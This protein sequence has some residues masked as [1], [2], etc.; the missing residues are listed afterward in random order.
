MN[1][2][3]HALAALVLG[4]SACASAPSGPAGTRQPEWTR[5]LCKD[6]QTVQATYPDTDTALLK[7]QGGAHTLHVAISGSGARY[8]GDGWQWWT[9]GMH[10][11]MLSPLA[12]G[13]GI[14]S[15]PGT[16]CHTD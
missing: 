1:I 2:R 9:K 16:A 10:D 12:P 6:G 7:I 14:A 5:Y 15:S 3:H 11:G 13:E 8:I 4:V